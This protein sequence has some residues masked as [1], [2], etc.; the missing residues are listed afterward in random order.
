MKKLFT[1]MLMSICMVLTANAGQIYLIGSDNTWAPDHASATLE[2]TTTAGVYEGEVTFTGNWFAVVKNLASAD[3]WTTLNSADNRFSASNLT[4]GEECSLD[5]TGDHSSNLTQLGLYKVTVD[6][7]KLT[8]K[9]VV[10]EEAADKYYVAGVDALGLDWTGKNE[11]LLMTTTDKT[12][13]TFTKENLTLEKGV[14]YGFKVVKN[15]ST[16]IPGGGNITIKVDETGIYSV[17]FTYVVGESA[18][19]ATATK[20]GNAEATKHTY[21]VCGWFDDWNNDIA[22]TESPEGTW[23]AEIT[24]VAAGSYQFKVRA[25]G[26][27]TISYPEGAVNKTLTVAED[28]T[29]VTIVFVESTK[30]ITITQTVVTSIDRVNAEAENAPAYNL[31]G[32]KASKGLVIKNNKKYILR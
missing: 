13:Y 19:T 6:L 2:E 22:M 4:I 20:T 28:N 3:D 5:Q 23:T 29:T 12:T 31:A 14:E 24:G 9:L 27:W 15:G 10:V 25:D 7:N 8:I 17:T 1:L 16:W 32:V 30:N 18:P 11:D 21:G 26:G